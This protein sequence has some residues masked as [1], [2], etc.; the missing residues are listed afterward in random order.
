[1]HLNAVGYKIVGQLSHGESFHLYSLLGNYYDQSLVH[2][3]YGVFRKCLCF[4]CAAPKIFE[5]IV[6]FRFRVFPCVPIK[7][8]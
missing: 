2:N 4:R 1:M 7:S 5:Q 6:A 3:F 8:Y